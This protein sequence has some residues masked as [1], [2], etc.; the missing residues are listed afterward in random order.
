MAQSAALEAV[1]TCNLNEK[2]IVKKRISETVK[3]IAT[4]LLEE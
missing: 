1:L 3:S 4:T 2:P